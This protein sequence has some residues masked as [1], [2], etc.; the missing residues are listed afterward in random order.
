MY[1]YPT[2]VSG[3][4]GNNIIILCMVAAMKV[5]TADILKAGSKMFDKG[6]W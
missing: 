2:V 3:G 5:D 4:Y 6:V 1:H